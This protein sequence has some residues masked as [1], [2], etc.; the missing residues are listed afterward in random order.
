[1]LVDIEEPTTRARK[2]FLSVVGDCL[3]G[4]A[5]THAAPHCAARIHDHRNLEV[6]S[7]SML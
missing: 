2:I 3:G 1:M 4:V 7:G 5:C 6:T